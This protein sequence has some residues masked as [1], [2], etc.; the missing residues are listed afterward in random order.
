MQIE[1]QDLG[2]KFHRE[3]VFRHINLHLAGG[4]TYVFVGPNGSGKSTL[5]LTLSGMLPATKGKV[6][7]RK[8]DQAL[9][10][11]LMYQYQSI[12]APYMEVIEEFSLQE[13]IDFHFSFKQPIAGYDTETIIQSMYLEKAKKKYIRQFSSGMKQ[14]LKLGLAFYSQS[15]IL[16]LDEP[17]SNLDNQGIQWYR[18]EV[19]KAAQ[20]K[21]IIICSNQPYEYDFCENVINIE[22]YK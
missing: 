12:V 21:L 5:L 17:C 18:E 22:Q 19:Q 8:E 9:P 15:S 14:R 13:M 20:N 11:E 1:V 2:K 6:I 3:W 10:D 7:Y 16:F 4:K